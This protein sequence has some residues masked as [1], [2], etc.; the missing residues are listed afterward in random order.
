MAELESLT[1]R[2][3][4]ARAE[5]PRALEKL[6][7]Q[8]TPGRQLPLHG[9]CRLR[10]ELEGYL[11]R[12]LLRFGRGGDVLLQVRARVCGADLRPLG[13]LLG[14]E[15]L[16]GRLSCSLRAGT[17][18]QLERKTTKMLMTGRAP[19]SSGSQPDWSGTPG[20]EMTF[21]APLEGGGLRL[22]AKVFREKRPLGRQVLA[23]AELDLPPGRHVHQLPLLCAVAQTEGVSGL[24]SLT[25]ETEV[26]VVHRKSSCDS[27]GSGPIHGVRYIC[28]DCHG[29]SLCAACYARWD[30]VHPGHNFFRTGDLPGGGAGEGGMDSP[31]RPAL[32][33]A[34]PDQLVFQSTVTVARARALEAELREEDLVVAL[35]PPAPPS[36]LLQEPQGQELVLAGLGLLCTPAG[37]GE[38]AGALVVRGFLSGPHAAAG[39]NQ[40]QDLAGTFGA[41][42]LEGDVITEVSTVP[43]VPRGLGRAPCAEGVQLR[44]RRPTRRAREVLEVL[45]G[46]RAA[47]RDIL[48]GDAAAAAPLHLNRGP[49][50]CG[51]C[52]AT[53]APGEA[54][55]LRPCGHGWFC[56]SC[57]QQWATSQ[58]VDGRCSVHCPIP[59][60]RTPIGH[61]QLRATL[62]G[63]DFERL[64]R[65]SVEQ[66]CAADDA[67][68]AC[69]TP[70][71][72]YRAWLAEHQEPQLVCELCHV[73]SCVRCGVAPYHHGLTCQ[74]EARRA[75]LALGVAARVR[76][77]AEEALREALVRKCPGCRAP[78]ER[79]TACCHMTCAGCNTEFSWVCGGAWETCRQF[80]HCVRRGVF[81]PGVLRPVSQRRGTEDEDL[82]EDEAT[83]LFLELRCV[84]LLSKL[85]KEV[86]AS[87]WEETRRA[88]P[89]LLH[90][91]IGGQR[92]VPWHK[93]GDPELLEL[94]SR[95]LPEAFPALG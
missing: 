80:H 6:V 37:E 94:L 87:A 82:G 26:E 49:E 19:S 63:P 28:A 54:I 66:L 64:V 12:A 1:A 73:E 74:E 86:G 58:A 67:L 88:C 30:E 9:L 7:P 62:S 81:L 39:W 14:E 11:S 79:T 69:P 75:E 78:I 55:R 46:D 44:I 53:A 83:D 8:A 5:A 72:P 68:V 35:A 77:R 29:C 45:G 18:T 92:D 50:T 24:L 71:C 52:T 48:L 17:P 70:D 22:R 31:G 3:E 16:A 27:C 25:V 95:V 15:A 91:V 32:Q 13:R 10:G 65:R 41:Q 47:A 2:L 93:V 33:A 60:C 89:D 36:L 61:R 42:L 90:Q 84:Y 43:V 34:S 85:R 57:I 38:A 21:M 56:R 4:R 51:I 40:D 76:R 20:C 23:A 59:E